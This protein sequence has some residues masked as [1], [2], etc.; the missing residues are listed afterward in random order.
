MTIKLKFQPRTWNDEFDLPDGSYAISRF[1]FEYVIKKHETIANNPPVQ[2][3]RNK[4][5]SRI[6]LK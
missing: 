3:Y 4:I 1:F 2:I 5:R 6:V